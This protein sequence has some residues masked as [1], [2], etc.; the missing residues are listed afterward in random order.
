MSKELIAVLDRSPNAQMIAKAVRAL[1]V[2][3]EVVQQVTDTTGLKGIIVAGAG[4]LANVQKPTL[5]LA[6]P[7]DKEALPEC[8]RAFCFNKCGCTGDFSMDAF[9]EET[10]RDIRAKVG[11]KQVLLAL[12]G[13]VD[14]AVCAMLIHRAVGDRLTCIFVDH[15]LMRKNEPALIK[16]VFKTTYK[17]NL[18]MVDAKQR[19]YDLLKDVI[20]P[21]Q[22]RKIIGEAF[23][24]V[25]EEEARKLGRVEYLAQGTIYPDILESEKGSFVKSHHNVGGLPE[26]TDF[27]GYV[28]PLR[29]LFKEEVR[30]CGRALGLPA[31]LTER[32]PFPGPGLGV[33]IIGGI[34]AEKVRIIQEADAIFREEVNKLGEGV[35]SQ[36]FAVLTDTRSTGVR[37]GARA[38]GCTVALRAVTTPDFMVADVAKLPYEMLLHASERIISEIPEVGR[39]VY[40]ITRKPPATVEWE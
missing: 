38:Y 6:D 37:D 39:V 35:A 8:L 4:E 17:I 19:Y 40:D 2:Y 33:R 7:I 26:H 15:G 24:R 10:I 14:S 36:Y 21:E 31:E 32:Q 23:I 34:T 16:Q 22:K 20:D 30:A 27:L 18:I 11:D 1:N 13:G 29:S 3:C 25:F 9:I 5:L 28:E 12:S